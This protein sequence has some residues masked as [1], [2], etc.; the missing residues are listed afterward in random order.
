MLL[1]RFS[2]PNHL[3][4]RT[5]A[6]KRANDAEWC[7]K[8]V[9]AREGH[10]QNGPTPPPTG[11]VYLQI[12][13]RNQGKKLQVFTRER[14]NENSTGEKK[15]TGRL[16]G[17]VTCQGKKMER[18]HSGNRGIRLM[19][20]KRLRNGKTGNMNTVCKLGDAGKKKGGRVVVGRITTDLLKGLSRPTRRLMARSDLR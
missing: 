4:E 15:G 14:T 11:K 6:P 19:G 7:Q 13:E 3:R 17:G 10:D 5:L 9:H 1:G 18:L 16:S 2:G 20:K 12:V 8:K